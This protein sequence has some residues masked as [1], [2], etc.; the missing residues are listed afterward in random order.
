MSAA[1]DDAPGVG[2]P[3]SSTLALLDLLLENE[4]LYR[5]R[6]MFFV[7]D[8]ELRGRDNG[9]S[10]GRYTAVAQRGGEDEDAADAVFSSRMSEET[11][12]SR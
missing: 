11:E 2:R 8:G 5:V 1:A 10:S 9:E 6:D 3:A 4:Q 7:G 12:W